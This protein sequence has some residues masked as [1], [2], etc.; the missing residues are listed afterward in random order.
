MLD[1]FPRSELFCLW[2]D[3]PSKYEGRQVHESILAKTFLRRKKSMALPAMPLI[4]R[5]LRFS[6]S[7]D[8]VLAS[9]HLFAHQATLPFQQSPYKKF[10]YAHTPARY[11]WVPELDRRGDALIPRL[12]AALLKPMDKRAAKENTEIAANSNFVRERIESTWEVESRV[13]YPPVDVD[14]VQAISSWADELSTEEQSLLD[15]L[16]DAFIL[17]ASRF[18][19]YKRL[20]LAIKAGADTGTPVVIAGQGPEESKLRAQ[21]AEAPVP[22]HFVIDPS[23]RMLFSLYERALVFCFPAI[24]DF[25]IMPVEAM[26]AGAPVLV[27]A[28]GGAAESV[29]DGVTGYHLHD[30]EPAT[31][32]NALDRAARLDRGLIKKRALAFSRSRFIGE[33]QNWIEPNSEATDLRELGRTGD[34]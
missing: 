31:F 29:V 16:P 9:S 21:A 14:R 15:S 33:L 18:V 28:V 20:D 30:F 10:V 1:A 23:D 25:G 11:L 3:D 2:N 26:A 13:I 5:S 7:F 22:V 34:V 24:E 6:K 4:W 27:N 32:Q 19:P 8:W 17:G 12:G